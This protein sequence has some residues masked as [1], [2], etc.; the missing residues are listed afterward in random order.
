V[1]ELTRERLVSRR[2]ALLV[3]RS[4]VESVLPG[5][6][7]QR[8]AEKT[9]TVSAF[10][11]RIYHHFD[12]RSSL[13]ELDRQFLESAIDL[14]SVDGAALL[15][16][17]VNG[18][19]FRLRAAKGLFER[20]AEGLRF[21]GLSRMGSIEFCVRNEGSPGDRDREQLRAATGMPYFLWTRHV[22]GRLALLLTK[23]EENPRDHPPFTDNSVHVAYSALEVYADLL[24]RRAAHRDVF[25]SELRFHSMMENI[26]AGIFRLGRDGRIQRSNP[27][28]YLMLGY[29]S[30]DELEAKGIWEH[31][32]DPAEG[33]AI[34]NELRERGAVLD[35]EVRLKK[36]DGRSLWASTTARA[37]RGPD[38]RI[39]C[40][41]GSVVDIDRRKEMEQ[42]LHESYLLS[43]EALQGAVQ[44]IMRM[45]EIRDPYTAGHQDRVA[46]LSR[47]IAREL[48]VEDGRAQGIYVA[49]ILHDVGK[50][51]VPAEI[52][53]KP[54]RITELERNVL[55]TH[56][57][58]GYEILKPVRF[59][60]PVAEIVYQHHERLDGPGYP[61]G[62]REPEIILE[63][64][65]LAVAD[66]VEAMLSHRP[67]RPGLG[68]EKALEEIETGSGTV[69][70]PSAVEACVRL[71]RERRFE[72]RSN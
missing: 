12:T 9:K 38:G 72:F 10:I 1:D 65:I 29:A 15:V 20:S 46:Q 6:G 53:N 34:M 66:V 19:G 63:A 70:D 4:V 42:E 71:F 21:E 69:Y 55:K 52:L 44:A 25:E 41:D 7:L 5:N 68:L 33:R 40:F 32:E 45:A 36:A 11:T 43:T 31:Y 51:Y 13:A 49:G 35:R 60:W 37:V 18:D 24:D 58:V 8:E 54:G 56:A 3:E 62:L 39:S 57:E 23:Q 47:A 16:R 28:L 2:K 48:G 27:A 67:Y 30:R 50:I 14:M 59:P 17:G 26:P 61:R 22:D 64:R